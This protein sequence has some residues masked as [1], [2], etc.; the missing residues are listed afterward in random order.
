MANGSSARNTY[1]YGQEQGYRLIDRVV[2]PDSN[3]HSFKMLELDPILVNFLK[4][5]YGSESLF[6]FDKN[7]K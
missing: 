5:G 6:K 7:V 4:Y 2:V 3:T 1:L